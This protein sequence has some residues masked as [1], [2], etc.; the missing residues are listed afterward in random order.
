VLVCHY[1]HST[2]SSL[3]IVAALPPLLPVPQFLLAPVIVLVSIEILRKH[4]HAPVH[5]DHD[6]KRVGSSR[7]AEAE[8]GSEV[9]K[10]LGARAGGVTVQVG[11]DGEAEVGERA[12]H[13]EG[14][15]ELLTVVEEVVGHLAGVDGR[16]VGELEHG[17]DE[18]GLEYGA[19]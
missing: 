2:I 15:E 10:L 3:T 13:V 7:N 6:Q 11:G 5:R 8:S 18:G 12:E 14:W 17:H 1:F 19:A 16:D 4:S 9:R